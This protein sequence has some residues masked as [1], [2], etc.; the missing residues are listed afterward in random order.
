M[1]RRREL[2]VRRRVPCEVDTGD[3]RVHGAVLD[4]APNGLF[5]QTRLR[6]A[7]RARTKLAVRLRVPPQ[8]AEVTLSAEVARQYRVP[9][10]LIA[11]AGGGIGL[12]IRTA[13]DAW[14]EFL[15]SLAPRIFGPEI[16]APTAPHARQAT[17]RCLLCGSP[18]R[19]GSTLCSRC[20]AVKA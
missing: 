7:G 19:P 6:L 13:P 5:V 1:N 8:N 4:L 9:A 11:A 18:P 10:A 12:R 3:R 14:G 20:M 16:D 15:A 2:R 17:V